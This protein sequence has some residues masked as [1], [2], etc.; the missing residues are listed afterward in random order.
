MWPISRLVSKSECIDDSSWTLSGLA[1]SSS[2]SSSTLIECQ[3]FSFWSWRFVLNNDAFLS[4]TMFTVRSWASTRT[5]DFRGSAPAACPSKVHF[6]YFSCQVSLFLERFILQV[7]R[8]DDLA[9]IC[10]VAE[11]SSWSDYRLTGVL[12]LMTA[13]TDMRRDNVFLH[14]VINNSHL[15]EFT[16]RE[17][18]ALLWNSFI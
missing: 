1:C 7:T 18:R 12:R 8:R 15:V 14:R 11:F 16:P 9:R 6:C 5:F 13:T 17:R 2:S 10:P 4:T 3:L